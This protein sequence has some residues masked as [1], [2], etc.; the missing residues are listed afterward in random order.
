MSWSGTVRCGWCHEE[1][2]NKRTCERYKKYLDK[3]SDKPY[4]AS[5]IEDR[6]TTKCSFCTGAG[7][8]KRTCEVKTK[9]KAALE[10][11]DNESAKT[12]S[13]LCGKL[14]IGRGAMVR[15]ESSWNEW[16]TGVVVGL[17]CGGFDA[18]AYVSFLGD[19]PKLLVALPNGEKTPAWAPH[20]DENKKK[21]VLDS[22]RSIQL[23][24]NVEVLLRNWGYTRTTMVAPGY[25]PVEP[26]KV[27]RTEPVKYSEGENAKFLFKLR[28]ATEKAKCL[29]E[30]LV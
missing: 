29:R 21:E 7:H 22:I 6:K 14:G 8:N 17:V 2:H 9:Q 4:I 20:I 11:W 18:H 23:R 19:E 3:Y 26:T 5:E 15:I 12:L 1:G 16:Q 13:Q 30:E 25:H 24:E 28:V 10:V 27:N